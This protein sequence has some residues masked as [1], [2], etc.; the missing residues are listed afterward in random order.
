VDNI[1]KE[2]KNR[3]SVISEGKSNKKNQSKSGI[4]TTENNREGGKL[5]NNQE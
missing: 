4:I 3:N 5:K 2:K 1:R